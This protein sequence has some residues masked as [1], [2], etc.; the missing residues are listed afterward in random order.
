MTINANAHTHTDTRK[1]DSVARCELTAYYVLA[2]VANDQNDASFIQLLLE[3]M[4]CLSLPQSLSVTSSKASPSFDTP[5][6]HRKSPCIQFLPKRNKQR[7][8]IEKQKNG[9]TNEKTRPETRISTNGKDEEGE[10]NNLASIGRH[11]TAALTH[12]HL[13]KGG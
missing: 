4:C 5:K 11:G 13:L 6:R 3:L 9:T 8:C 10:E 12:T 1:G 7:L 2:T